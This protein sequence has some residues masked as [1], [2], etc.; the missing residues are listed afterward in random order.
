[1]SKF[2]F[3]AESVRRGTSSI[4]WD[5]I[6]DGVIGMSIADS[7]WA[8][9]PAALDA[10][11]DAIASPKTFG[12]GF[13]DYGLVDAVAAWYKRVYG[14]DVDRSWILPI[15]G[16]VP[17]FTALLKL[18]ERDALT[19]TPNYNM[20]LNSPARVGKR[21]ITS[22]MIEK[23]ADG[24]LTY[25][26]DFDDLGVKAADAGVFFLVNPHNPIGYVYSR[27][28]L[29]E[30]A[31][32]A[33]RRDL[34]VIADEIHAEIVYDKPHVPWFTVAP[35]NSVTLVAS[36]KVCNMPGIP[37]ALAIVPD[38]ALRERVRAA[39]GRTSLGA[40]NSIAI[41]GAF[42]EGADEWKRAQ[43]AHLKSVRD[44]LISGLRAALPRIRATRTEGTYLQWLDLSDYGLG[45]A[46]K[47]LLANAR[48]ATAGGVSYGGGE[49][50]IRINFAASH[51]RAAEAVRR[52]TD[53]VGKGGASDGV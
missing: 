15:P 30:I 49:G 19:V 23:A 52:I 11:R 43:A 31:A 6:P 41:R 44:E 39:F 22:P 40:L 16:I 24:T 3:D 25:A 10:V 42:G 8:T 50:Y 34:I 21:M 36:G 46:Q 17:A 9:A 45:D 48:V 2:D 1:M 33:K 5:T 51:A 12:Y 4:K 37:G 32:F 28:E 38:E 27:E 18:T 20:L 53:A 14:A 26:Y 13:N 47:F 29:A 7:D 35:E